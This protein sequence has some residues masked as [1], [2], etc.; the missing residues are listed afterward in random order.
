MKNVIRLLLLVVL[1]AAFS[2]AVNAQSKKQRFSREQLAEAQA[3]FISRELALDDKTSVRFIDAYCRYQRDLWA[4]GPRQ[5]HKKRP[6]TDEEAEEAVR[7]R[8][9]HSQNILDLRKKYYG[10]YSEFLTQTQI[11]RAYELEWK[12]INRLNRRNRTERK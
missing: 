4:L 6:M 1:S 5:G 11:Q 7:D 3:K 9:V 2:G 12:M 8:F 10:I